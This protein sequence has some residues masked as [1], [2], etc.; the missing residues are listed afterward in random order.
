MTNLPIA[1]KFLL[2]FST[3]VSCGFIASFLIRDHYWTAGVI[4]FSMAVAFICGACAA[5]F[6]APRP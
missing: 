1:L 5:L 6:P 3:A 4:F 2:F